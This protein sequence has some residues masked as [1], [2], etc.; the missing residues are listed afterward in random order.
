ME[1]LMSKKNALL[2]LIDFQERI[3]PSMHNKEELED[4]TVRLTKACR[5]L[6]VPV[7]A[8]A[9]YPKGLGAI[10]PAV[11]E[12]MGDE[13]CIIEKTS[14]SCCGQDGF[15]DALEEFDRGTVLVA[16]IESH[17]CVQ[18][19]VLE[20]LEEGFNVYLLAD[21]VSSRTSYDKQI[22]L[23]RMSDEGAYIVT[24]ESAVFEMLKNAKNP[25]FKSISAIVK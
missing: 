23:R 25:A 2:L 14:F 13:A 1:A 8:T 10:I 17:V 4:K 7:M 9:Q 3:M 22:A 12:A 16:G 24:Y 20:L 19:T 18:Q 5:A 15:M 11:R 6:G 21:C